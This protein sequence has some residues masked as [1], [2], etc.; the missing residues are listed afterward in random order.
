MN[1]LLTGQNGFVGKNLLRD[2]GFSSHKI[3]FIDREHF[4]KPK[5][6]EDIFKDKPFDFL[7]HLASSMTQIGRAHV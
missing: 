3:T 7:I 1:I 5:D 2:K 6:I 4:Q